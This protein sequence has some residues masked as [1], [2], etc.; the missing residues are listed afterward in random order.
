MTDQPDAVEAPHHVLVI[1]EA[2]IDIVRRADG[3]VDEHAGGSPANVALGLARLGHPVFFAT[4]IGDDDHG[5]L[6][7]EHLSKDGVE[8]SSGSVTDRPTSV[9]VATLDDTGAA[10]Y[11]FEITWEPFTELPTG[12]VTHVH[13]GSIATTLQPGSDS[14]L[15]HFLEQRE[16]VTL[17]YDPNARPSLMGDPADVRPRVEQ[18]VGLSD[19]VKASDEDIE[20]LYPGVSIPDVLRR[21]GRLG[22]LLTIATFGGSGALARLRSGDDLFI[23]PAVK[24]VDTVGA[25]DSFMAGLVSGL[26]DD[27]YL[28]SPAARERLSTAI[29]PE[30]R[31]AIGRAIACAAITVSR[32]GADPPR[33]D[34]L[35]SATIGR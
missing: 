30:V 12:D 11:Q 7:S 18:L 2:L 29:A 16:H 25:G 33:R 9:A 17:S 32:P 20:W 31:P 34:E 19:V 5:R 27:G 22:A 3:S 28:G 14:V 35:P 10:S 21:W 15:D 13:A 8:L 4:Q 6:I 24:V 26:L 1:G 23:A